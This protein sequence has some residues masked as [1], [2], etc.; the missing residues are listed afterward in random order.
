MTSVS[1]TSISIVSSSVSRVDWGGSGIG[2]VSVVGNGS[3]VRGMGNDSNVVGVAGGVG[4]GNW[5]SSGDLSNG[6]GLRVSFSLTLAVVVSVGVAEGGVSCNWGDGV[7]VSSGVGVVGG[8]GWN[9]G[10]SVGVAD[11]VGSVG[12]YSNVVGVAGGVGVGDWKSSGD[13]SDGVG[14]RV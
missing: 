1:K 10:S 5:K 12:D 9:S 11:W 6:V 13:L 8:V 2:G 7:S 14:I 3:R 4:V